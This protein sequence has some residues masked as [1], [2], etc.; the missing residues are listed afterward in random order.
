[1]LFVWEKK[2]DPIFFYIAGLY[3]PGFWINVDPSTIF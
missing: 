2:K 1:L 3:F